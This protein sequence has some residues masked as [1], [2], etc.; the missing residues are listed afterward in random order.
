[1]VLRLD[2]SQYS[3]GVLTKIVVAGGEEKSFDGASRMLR[4]LADLEIDGR[5]VNRWTE[6]IGVELA[7]AEAERT[8][9]HARQELPIEVENLPEAVVVECDGGR[10]RVRAEGAGAGVHRPAWRES[11]NACLV[12]V[13]SETHAE[14]PHPQLPRCFA[15]RKYMAELVR[16]LKNAE[17]IAPDAENGVAEIP[18][19]LPSDGAADEAASWTPKRLVRTCVSGLCR[20]AE[21]GPRVAAEARR[22]GFDQ[23]SRAAFLGDG[24]ACNWAI[25]QHHFP[26][27]LPI[28]D[29]IHALG[30]VYLAARA[31][32]V[33]AEEG[34]RIYLRWATACWQGRVAEVLTE[35]HACQERLG[36]IPPAEEP[37]ENDP[38]LVIGKTTTYL[39]HN[40]GRMQYPRY[41]CLGLPVTSVL[42]ESLIKEINHRVKGTEK[43]WNDPQGADAILH[44]RA[45]LLSEDN[46]LFQYLANRPGSPYYRP[47]IQPKVAA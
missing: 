2:S 27:Y 1:M 32:S 3:P 40:R 13:Q 20:S 21:F 36:P 24:Q 9:Q 45:A 29:F 26:G 46:R 44:V 33:D 39:E 15:D 34:W 14:D 43:F 6:R 5:Q 19:P 18:P 41:R 22:R 31:A 35:L 16:G 8:A 42:I 4:H 37:P 38:R 17:N 10:I 47:S 25:R 11:K 30:Y 23:A 12:R 28:L 7:E